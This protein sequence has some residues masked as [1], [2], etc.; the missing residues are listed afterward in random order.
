MIAQLPPVLPGFEDINRFFDKTRNTFV[1][2]IL[3]GEFY[4]TRQEELVATTLGS[5]VSACIWDEKFGV[6]GMNHFMLP[7]TEE[8]AHEV[9]WGN[10][11][12]LAT[13]YGNYAMEHLVNEILKYGGMRKFLSAKVVGGGQVSGLSNHIGAKNS[14]FVLDYLEKEGIPIC[15]EDLLGTH[16][17]KVLFDPVTGRLMVKKL[18]SMHNNTIAARERWYENSLSNQSIE[19]D[20]ELF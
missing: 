20:V 9:N 15:S 4:V 8:N 19:G 10:V 12:G 7:L 11:P 3:P 5:C 6:G 1:A 18:K 17:R 2:K 13:R 16:P 14:D